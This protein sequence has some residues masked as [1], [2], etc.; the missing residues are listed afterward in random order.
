M[1]WPESS[2][3]SP[4]PRIDHGEPRSPAPVSR[5]A[6]R[7]ELGS[8]VAGRRIDSVAGEDGMGRVYRAWNLRLKRV[9]AVKVIV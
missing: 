1:Q 2:L 9:E 6:A 3:R 4:R 5:R 7:F 8:V